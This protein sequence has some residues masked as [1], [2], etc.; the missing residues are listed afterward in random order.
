MT[1]KQSLIVDTAVNLIAE[2][3]FKKLSMKKIAEEIGVSEPAL[4]RHFTGKQDIMMAILEKFEQI[5]H[6][7]ISKITDNNLQGL[8]SIKTFILNRYSLFGQN[9]KLTKVMMSEDIFLYNDELADRMLSIMQNHKKLLLKSINEAEAL[10]EIKPE[11]EP[12]QLF[13]IIIGSMRFT[14]NQWCMHNYNFDLKSEGEL[15]WKTLII[16]M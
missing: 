16:M 1:E 6:N 11:L 14:I 8:E 12:A 2:N 5:A 15:L 10:G 3:G 13:R 9:P 7:V 4:Y